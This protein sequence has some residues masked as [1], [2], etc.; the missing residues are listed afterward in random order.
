[1]TCNHQHCKQQL[2][3]GGQ[4]HTC[5]EMSLLVVH[6]GPVERSYRF[7]FSFSAVVDFPGH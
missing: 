7:S 1:M 6:V 2:I 5:F 4:T 3:A